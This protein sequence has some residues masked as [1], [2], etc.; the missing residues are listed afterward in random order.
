MKRVLCSLLLAPLGLGVV[1][2][3]PGMMVVA[4]VRSAPPCDARAHTPDVGV[5]LRDAT[6]VYRCNWE[7]SLIGKT[8]AAGRVRYQRLGLL[9]DQCLLVVS[10][11]G[12]APQSFRVGD[13]CAVRPEAFWG[14]TQCSVANISAA[15]TPTT[16]SA[17]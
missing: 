14:S 7:D 12:Y 16:A 11:E 8:D 3:D 5:A 10:R 17:P 6:I 13:V 4:V 15:L 1:G 2:C 9:A